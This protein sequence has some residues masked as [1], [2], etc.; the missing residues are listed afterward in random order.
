MDPTGAARLLR[1]H[2][3]TLGWWT[4]GRSALV[5]PA[6]GRFFD[7]E[8]LVSLLVIAE[9]WRRH[10]PAD[11]IRQGVKALAKELSAVVRSPMSMRLSCWQP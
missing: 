1:V 8:D 7:F 6:F 10:V 2:P 5:K 11:E 9:L 4:I 3:E